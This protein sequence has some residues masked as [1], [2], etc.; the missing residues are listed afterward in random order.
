[1]FSSDLIIFIVLSIFDATVS[2]GIY[3]IP[4]YADCPKIKYSSYPTCRYCGQKFNNQ[5]EIDAHAM[6]YVGVDD[7]HA[8]AGYGATHEDVCTKE[9]WTETINH[10][11]EYKTVYECE[12]GAIK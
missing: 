11:A 7:A 1:M 10:P 8:V 6:G 2:E 9:A 3:G 4:E 5:A 12:C